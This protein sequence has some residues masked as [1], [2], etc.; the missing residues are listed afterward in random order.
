MA[1]KNPNPKMDFKHQ[2]AKMKHRNTETA[3]RLSPTAYRLPSIEATRQ[4]V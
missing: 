3:H 2:D 1:Q 4:D